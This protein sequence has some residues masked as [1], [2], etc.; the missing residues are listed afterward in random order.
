MASKDRELSI[1]DRS[2]ING[3]INYRVNH[4]IKEN[5]M[6]KT[7]MVIFC[8]NIKLEMYVLKKR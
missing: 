8:F 2:Q 1:N 4:G 7:K 3:S 5:E 6:F